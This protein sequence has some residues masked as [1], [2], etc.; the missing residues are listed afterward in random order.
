MLSRGCL[1]FEC[2]LTRVNHRKKD[3]FTD[4]VFNSFSLLF[5]WLGSLT[6]LWFLD[7][8]GAGLLSLF[9]I[10]DWTTLSFAHVI[11]LSGQSAD[12]DLQ[13]KLLYLAWRFSPIVS[14]FKSVKSYH[15]VRALPLPAFLISDN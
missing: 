13:K 14:G 10:Y 15:N 1:H 6:N 11:R 7:P 8:L 4:V 12:Q 5:P 3:C 9:I 2:F